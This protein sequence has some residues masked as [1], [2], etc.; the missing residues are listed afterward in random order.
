MKTTAQALVAGWV[1]AAAAT[2]PAAAAGSTHL[3]TFGDWEA[4]TYGDKAAKVCFA[5]SMPKSTRNPPAGRAR[6]FISVTHRP[7]EK[8]LNVVSIDAGFPYKA[9]SEA[10]VE[11][12]SG[13][14][15]LFTDGKSAWVQEAADDKA[16]VDAMKKGNSLTATGQPA[17]GAAVTDS[18]S[19]SGFSAAYARIG[20]ACGVK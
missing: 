11:I 10:Q 12:G 2:G 8:S 5:A 9:K 13:K 15:K 19:L 3:G 16:L 20:E 17:K 14:F 4:Y 6:A 1:L 18:Y 7:G